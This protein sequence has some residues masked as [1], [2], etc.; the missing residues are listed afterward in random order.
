MGSDEYRMQPSCAATVDA[1]PRCGHGGSEHSCVNEPSVCRHRGRHTCGCG[2]TWRVEP[3]SSTCPHGD[4]TCPCPDG[5]L[6][7]YEGADAWLS[8]TAERPQEPTHTRWWC[9]DCDTSG[10]VEHTNGEGVYEVIET[11]RSAHA[12]ASN[13]RHTDIARVRVEG[14]IG[15]V[16]G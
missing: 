13:G 7:H 16:D 15:R 4:A 9:E 2:A 8:P 10:V 6:C 11:L 12:E 3:V 1:L 14:Y 5:D